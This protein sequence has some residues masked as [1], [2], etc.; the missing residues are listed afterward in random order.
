M[1]GKDNITTQRNRTLDL[2]KGIAIILV[3]FGHSIQYGSGE[4]FYSSKAYFEYWFFQL[5]YSFHMPLFMLVSGYLFYY[6]VKKYSIKTLLIS[7][8]TKLI[9][10]IVAWS[11]ILFCIKFP[12]MFPQEGNFGLL[13]IIKNYVSMTI[14]N[15]WFIWAVFYCSITVIIVN[16]FFRD[17]ILVYGII[18][19]IMLVTPDIYNSNLYKFMYPYFILA[20]LFSKYKLI[21][22]VSQLSKRSKGWIG[23]ITLIMYFGLFSFY[24]YNIFIYTTGITLLEKNISSQLAIDIYRWLIGLLGSGCMIGIGTLLIGKKFS[25]V[26]INNILQSLGK[27][28]IGIYIISTMFIN[29]DILLPITSTYQLNIILLSIETVVILLVCYV[30]SKAIQQFKWSNRA[31]LGSR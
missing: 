19:V 9:F 11:T 4:E 18:G 28:S 3:V 6:T 8:F 17:S 7:R 10:P 25:V 30:L 24:N 13:E 16:K 14:Y 21:L 31:L 1:S 26:S 15:L 27:N 22:K 20:Y 23:I 2:I 12:H 5:I 29:D